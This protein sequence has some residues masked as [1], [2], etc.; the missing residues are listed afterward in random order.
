MHCQYQTGWN[1]LIDYRIKF[2]TVR[3]IIIRFCRF[4]PTWYKITLSF[5]LLHVAGVNLWI[6]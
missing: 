3:Q 2:S 1:E 5:R 6:D 4:D